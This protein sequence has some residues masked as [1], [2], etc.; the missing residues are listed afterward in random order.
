[1]E[2]KV[3]WIEDLP[4]EEQAKEYVEDLEGVVDPLGMAKE[5]LAICY[6]EAKERG[7]EVTDIDISLNCG[8]FIDDDELIDM[9]VGCYYV[10]IDE[11]YGYCY[12]AYCPEF[13]EMEPELRKRLYYW[14][15]RL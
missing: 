1:V 2:K 6:K 9:C 13:D 12:V 14:L 4:L 10:S 15:E 3:E 5:L 7:V 11:K 8:E